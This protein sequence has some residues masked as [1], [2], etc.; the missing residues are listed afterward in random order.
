MTEHDKP[1]IQ[2]DN[3]DED[4]EQQDE[5]LEATRES[6]DEHT[7]A[8]EKEWD[9]PEKEEFHTRPEGEEPPPGSPEHD[10]GIIS[11]P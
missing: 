2:R 6:A 7:K 1:I 8:K 9:G 3:D 5:L 4:L 11:G 10:R